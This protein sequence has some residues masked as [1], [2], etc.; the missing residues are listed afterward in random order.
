[1]DV[2]D[3][4]TQVVEKYRDKVAV[5][6]RD[7][8]TTFAELDRLSR[9]YAERFAQLESA[10]VVVGYEQGPHAYAAMLGAMMS[11]AC[12][13]PLNSAAPRDKIA[14]ICKSFEPQIAVGS[15]AMLAEV[16]AAS[17][18]IIALGPKD[19]EGCAGFS[20]RGGRHAV[21]Y[22]IYTSGSTGVPKG[23]MISHRAMSH[24]IDWV[25]D[26]QLFDPND[27]VSQYTNIA[28]DVSVL[29]IFGA[30]C[31]GS[32]TVP[33]VS[34]S[35]RVMPAQA[36]CREGVTVWVSVPSV[37][38]LMARAN[39]L[40]AQNLATVRRLF[41]AGEPLLE[42]HCQGI[43]AARPDAEI[44]NAYGPTETTVTMTCL[45]LNADTYRSVVRSCVALGDP[46]PGIQVCLL[47]GP[48]PDEG[49]IV[50]AGPQVAE[51]Y[52]NAREQ[53]ER[54]FRD[55][56]LNG[57]STRAYF[58][59][60]W[61]RRI[62]GRLYFESR[63]DHQVKINGYRIEL[64][65][66]AAAI[67]SLG[68]RE[69]AVLKIAGELTAIIEDR[70]GMDA[71]KVEGDVHSGLKD[72]LDRYAIPSRVVTVREFP[73]THNDKTDLKALAALVQTPQS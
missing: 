26:S 4:F 5:R 25:V 23:V 38:S 22:V 61:G 12:Y 17:P 41:F 72:K 57:A 68:W 21:A 65:E 67:R 59:G 44:W 3:R 29:D 10:R 42:T 14:A 1:M 37:I 40:T 15:D 27:R 32:T 70:D 2:I 48:D 55:I 47:G 49:E 46:I 7:H 66:V 20:D 33:F 9:R 34:R 56:E 45:P 30:L 11:G 43:F 36:V 16:R 60:D 18:G 39:Q 19:V 28:F 71:T 53:T 51:G 52:W 6:T 58:S 8:T 50:I 35:D 24:Y 13:A 54:V 64:N 62:D 73:R 63:I 69:V 31:T